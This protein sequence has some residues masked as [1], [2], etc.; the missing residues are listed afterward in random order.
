[1]IIRKAKSKDAEY[2][3]V[4]YFE[5]LTAYPPIEEQDMDV[6]ANLLDKFERDDEDDDELT[7]LA[8]QISENNYYQNTRK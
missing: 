6:W 1:M 8:E 2:L 4:L 7:F 3:K 5:Y